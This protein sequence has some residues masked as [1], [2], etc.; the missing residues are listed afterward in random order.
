MASKKIL[1]HKKTQ[2]PLSNISNNLINKLNAEL[3]SKNYYKYND[4][5]IILLTFEKYYFRA[6]SFA[7]LTVLLMEENNNQKADITGFGGG[8]GIF[9]ISWGANTNFAEQAK[10]ILISE[11]FILS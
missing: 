5:K 3:T 2:I 8:S 1:M 10:E 4:C 11:G 7:G 9:N 6:S